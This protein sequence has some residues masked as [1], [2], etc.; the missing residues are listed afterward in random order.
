MLDHR[1]VIRWSRIE[2]FG[3]EACEDA[4]W[5]MYVELV[6]FSAGARGVAFAVDP[7]SALKF[8]SW[9]EAAAAAVFIIHHVNDLYEDALEVVKLVEL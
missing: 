2:T 3:T 6:R 4:P 9:A 7:G 1:Y 5:Y 8:G